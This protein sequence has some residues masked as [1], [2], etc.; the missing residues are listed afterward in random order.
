M[1]ENA[2][3]ETKIMNSKSF[4]VIVKSVPLSPKE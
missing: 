4:D 2:M 1:I 3:R